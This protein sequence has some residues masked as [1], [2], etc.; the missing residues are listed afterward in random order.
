MNAVILAGKKD[1]NKI[2]GAAEFLVLH[3]YWI[4]GM[5]KKNDQQ[6]QYE[7]GKTHFSSDPY[8][9]Y[10]NDE[11]NNITRHYCDCI[12][13]RQSGIYTAIKKAVKSSTLSISYSTMNENERQKYYASSVLLPYSSSDSFITENND[14]GINAPN[15]PHKITN[16]Y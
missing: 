16:Q 15:K 1:Q 2:A 8:D 11:N 4:F 9:D 5:G 7:R 10:Y 13:T 3:Y 6:A 14:A 12:T